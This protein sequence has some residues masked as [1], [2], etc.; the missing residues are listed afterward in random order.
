MA[1]DVTTNYPNEIDE[2][3]FFSDCDLPHVNILT[4]YKE[5]LKQEKYTEARDLL[6]N[7]KMDFYGSWLLNRLENQLNAVGSYLLT[8]EKPQLQVYSSDAPT[9]VNVGITWIGGKI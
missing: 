2:R 5:L 7:S 6:N 3:I 8:K 9:N 1:H 4:E